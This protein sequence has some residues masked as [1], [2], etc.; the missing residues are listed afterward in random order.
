MSERRPL[1]LNERHNRLLQ[2][3][4]ASR[5][6]DPILPSSSSGNV[7]V[8]DLVRSCGFEFEI[9]F[10]FYVEEMKTVKVK[11]DGRRRLCKVSFVEPKDEN[12]PEFSGFS[13][14]DSPGLITICFCFFIGCW[15]FR[16]CV[17]MW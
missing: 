12:A 11:I 1:S 3:L 6:R 10:V 17:L 9:G 13:D 7:I 15:L 8:S 2:H 4:S 5:P 16:V 14:F